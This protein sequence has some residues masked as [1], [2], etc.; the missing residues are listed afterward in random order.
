MVL[1]EFVLLARNCRSFFTPKCLLPGCPPVH[2]PSPLPPSK[3]APS[4]K[5]SGGCIRSP[6]LLR[7]CKRIK[8]GERNDLACTAKV[9][10]KV[11]LNLKQTHR[12]CLSTWCQPPRVTMKP[13]QQHLTEPPRFTLRGIS[14]A[15]EPLN[16]SGE[17]ATYHVQTNLRRHD[18]DMSY[19]VE[20]RPQ[21]GKKGI[22]PKLDL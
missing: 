15:T 1:S 7:R 14:P 17:L 6:T 19:R 20:L 13:P 8:T 4:K 3:N 18:K 11:N 2:Y 16:T 21:T 12:R 5:A 10:R 22:H 9:C